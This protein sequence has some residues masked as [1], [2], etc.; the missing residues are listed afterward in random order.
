M[1]AAAGSGWQRR[2][3][4][5]GGEATRFLRIC[6]TEEG[7]EKA[8]TRFEGALCGEEGKR[9]G[10]GYPR[11]FVEGAR[12]GLLWENKEKVLARLEEKRS[13]KGED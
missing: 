9:R 2:R 7:Y 8:W 12:E 1:A 13:E 4:P 6:S 11:A 10:R 3:A 5:H